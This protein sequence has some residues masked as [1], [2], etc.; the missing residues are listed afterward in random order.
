MRWEGH[1]ART[2][3]S[4]GTCSVLASIPEGKRPPVNSRRRWED[5]IIMDLR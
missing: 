3:E 4:I 2:E 5:N 1:V